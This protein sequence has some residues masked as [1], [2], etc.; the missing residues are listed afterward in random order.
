MTRAFDPVG[1]I[2]VLNEHAV[3]FIVIGGFAGN[4][5]GSPAITYDLD[6]CYERSA[7]NCEALVRALRALGA[8]LRGAP[9]GLPFQLDART[10]LMGDSFTFD[11]TA[12]S[13]DCLGTPAGTD[14]YTDLL[15][16]AREMEIEEGRSVLVCSL[17]DLM[18]MKRTA[19]RPK[20]LWAVELL[21]TVKEEQKRKS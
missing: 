10:I 5:L 18:R 8:T 16:S 6:I 15:T 3:Q 20:D 21:K 19:G 7:A 17:D 11:T 13:V 2:R 12:G 9:A 14:G 1:A 4:I